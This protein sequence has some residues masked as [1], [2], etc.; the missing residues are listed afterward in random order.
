MGVMGMKPI[1]PAVVRA[2]VERTRR[3]QGLPPY[4]VDP[5][6]IARIVALLPSAA[7]QARRGRRRRSCGPE[8]PD[9]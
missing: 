2:W 3:E 6:F 5:V 7:R 4:P 9:G 8:P 1:D